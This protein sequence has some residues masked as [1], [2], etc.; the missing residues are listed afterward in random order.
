MLGG[1]REVE[2]LF[3]CYFTFK[4][5][6]IKERKAGKVLGQNSHMKS[7]VAIMQLNENTN[8]YDEA[9]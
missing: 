7:E 1:Q 4:R 8:V 9:F 3:T 6:D 2:F 5:S